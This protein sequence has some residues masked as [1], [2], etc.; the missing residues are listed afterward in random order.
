MQLLAKGKLTKI[1]K[2]RSRKDR[3]A[4]AGQDIQTDGRKDREAGAGKDKET[5]AG[6]DRVVDGKKDREIVRDSIL[7]RDYL[8]VF[9][10]DGTLLYETG[11]DK[12]KED[13]TNNDRLTS[14][15]EQQDKA[16]STSQRESGRQKGS[17]NYNDL[18]KPQVEVTKASGPGENSYKRLLETERRKLCKQRLREKRKMSETLR[19]CRQQA[20]KKALETTG[21]AKLHCDYG[22][23]SEEVA[24]TSNVQDFPH[25]HCEDQARVDN[26]E[27]VVDNDDKEKEKEMK[28][29]SSK[30]QTEFGE[31]TRKSGRQKTVLNYNDVPA[32]KLL[33]KPQV[34]VVRASGPADNS[35]E[36]LQGIESRE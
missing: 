35:N 28:R 13:T 14:H 3:E 18:Q 27:E 24:N 12:T 29:K 17:L 20:N 8:P 33:P 19:K 7:H 31:G 5:E 10:Q 22:N 36:R 30:I 26:N 34:E 32:G 9:L 6:K 15:A 16:T 4:E 2:Q 21:K 23:I 25:D 1:S 11:V